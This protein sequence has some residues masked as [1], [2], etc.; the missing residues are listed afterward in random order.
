MLITVVIQGHDKQNKMKLVVTLT[1]LLALNTSLGAGVEKLMSKTEYINTWSDVAVEQM[2]KHNIPASITLAQGILESGSGNSDLAKKGNNHF[3]IKCHDWTGKKMYKD[4]DKKDECF[5]VYD[6][7]KESYEDHSLFLVNKQRYASLFEYD[8]RDYKAWAHGLRKAGYATNPKYPELL[9]KIIEEQ[10]LAQY[11]KIQ[12]QEVIRLAKKNEKAKENST[13]SS[14]KKS[15]TTIS[16]STRQVMLHDNKV[17]YVVAQRGDT[18]YRIAKEFDLGLWQ[19]YKYNDIVSQK[20]VLEVGDIIY[21]QP[22]RGRSKKS[23]NTY[24]KSLTI[25]EIAQIE[26]VRLK[27][28]MKINGLSSENQVVEKGDKVTLR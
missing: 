25:A 28:L 2:L 18:Y 15:T 17:K 1:A 22:K 7:A 5:R 11:D 4:D 9:I 10:N 13:A 24:S 16:K 26:A 23:A 27:K 21:I 20:D 3:G 19:L 8:V 6:S 12:G 14:A